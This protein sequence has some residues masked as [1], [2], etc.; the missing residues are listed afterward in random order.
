MRA[1]CIGACKYHSLFFSYRQGMHLR[2]FQVVVG[3][4]ELSKSSKHSPRNTAVV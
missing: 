4:G 1:A 2:F 3:G